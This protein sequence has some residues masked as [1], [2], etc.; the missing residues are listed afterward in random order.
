MLLLNRRKGPFDLK[1]LKNGDQC[2]RFSG[3]TT[4]TVSDEEG[5]ALLLYKDIVQI[6]DGK[7]VGGPVGSKPVP[8]GTGVS[9]KAV[10]SE[11]AA[12]K[13]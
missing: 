6:V 5:K 10:P 4:I 2:R 3:G 8:S 12:K 7:Q 1:P 9:G 13:Q 11:P